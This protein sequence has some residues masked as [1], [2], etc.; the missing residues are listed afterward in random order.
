MRT[1]LVEHYLPG[2]SPTGMRGAAAALRD[3]AAAL[4]REGRAVRYLRSTI[5]PGDEAFLSLYEAGS[6]ALIRETY[7][8][9]GVSFERISRALAAEPEHID[10]REEA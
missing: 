7:V 5:V 3:A 1:Y 6:E 2:A 9:A 4:G 8:R 10:D